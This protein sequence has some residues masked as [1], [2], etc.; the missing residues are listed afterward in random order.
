MPSGNLKYHEIHNTN[1][2]VSPV[3]PEYDLT[4]ILTIAFVFY[5]LLNAIHVFS[6][7]GVTLITEKCLVNSLSS[8]FM[9]MLF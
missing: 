4:L 7:L 1:H 6:N 2:E 8:S 5:K 3:L 9:Q